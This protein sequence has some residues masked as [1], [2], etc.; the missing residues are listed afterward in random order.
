MARYYPV[1][2]DLKGR[3]CVVIGGG[4]V[5][6]RKVQ[7]L[8]ESGAVVTIISPQVTPRIRT[9]ADGGELQLQPRE[10]ADGDLAGV[11]LA[12]AA[13]DQAHVNRAIVVEAAREKVVLNVVDEP[14]LCTFIAPS[15]VNRG[16]V[17]VAISTSGTSPALARKLRESLE[18]SDLLDYSE[19]VGTLSS[20]RKEIRR[21]GRDVHQDKWQESI[22]ND[23]LDLVRAGKSR[24]ALDVLLGRLLNGSQRG[25]GAHS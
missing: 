9:L 1:F 15:I 2:L 19:L 4:E 20:A 12:I 7:T 6:E 17:T 5:A 14:S 22:S 18:K 8:L 16:E 21:L 10:Y 25:S 13:T 24:Q 3:L 11:F 23:L